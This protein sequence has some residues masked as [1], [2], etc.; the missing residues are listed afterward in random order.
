[1]VTHPVLTAGP[2]YRVTSFI[3]INA[4]PLSQNFAKVKQ[5]RM[6]TITAPTTYLHYTLLTT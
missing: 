2:T 6:L 5:T 3:E 4:Q 1:M